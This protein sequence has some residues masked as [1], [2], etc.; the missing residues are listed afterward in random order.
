MSAIAVRGW[1]WIGGRVARAGPVKVPN[2]VK[3]ELNCH[4]EPSTTVARVRLR[5]RGGGVKV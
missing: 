5:G 3:I 1:G 4:D 2:L